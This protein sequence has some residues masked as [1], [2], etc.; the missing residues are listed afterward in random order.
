MGSCEL[1]LASDLDLVVVSGGM[2]SAER[3][4]R[5]VRALVTAVTAPTAQGTFRALDMRL[6]PSGRAGP[7]VTTLPG[8]V[9]HHGTAEAWE[10]VALARARV[11]PLGRPAHE[12]A[13][14]EAIRGA[15]LAPRDDARLADEARAMLARVHADRPPERGGTTSS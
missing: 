4:G 3:D 5:A 14:T 12:A 11:L 15:L 7:L 6:R 8:F 9:R 10:L 13:V 2:E 1:T